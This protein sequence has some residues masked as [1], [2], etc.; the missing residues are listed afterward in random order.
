M[1]SSDKSKK[2]SAA[3]APTP[4]YKGDRSARALLVQTDESQHQD[5]GSTRIRRKP[6]T[7]VDRVSASRG[8][9]GQLHRCKKSNNGFDSPGWTA[10]P[11]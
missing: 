1:P 9:R 8:N 10:G 4:R 2:T 6:G 7:Q 11:S 5:Y 3:S